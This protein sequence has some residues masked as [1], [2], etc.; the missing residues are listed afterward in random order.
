M[1]IR[2][3][4]L[5]RD[6]ANY[7]QY[8]SEVFT[9][10]G[11]LS[12]EEVENRLRA[13]LIDGDWFYNHNWDLKDLHVYVWDNEIDHTWHEFD[14]VELTTELATKGDILELIQKIEAIDRYNI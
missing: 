12:I 8:H 5:Y 7:K 3:N 4:Y 10:A 6:G 11:L 1:N 9:N 2:L 13:Q 14:C